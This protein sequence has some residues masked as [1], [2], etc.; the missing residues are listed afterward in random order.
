LHSASVLKL[1]RARFDHAS[2]RRSQT[3]ATGLLQQLLRTS[4]NRRRAP[5]AFVPPVIPRSPR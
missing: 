5:N 4:G 1:E 3:T 2:I